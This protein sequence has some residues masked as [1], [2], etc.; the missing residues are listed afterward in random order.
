MPEASNE[1]K[2]INDK[3]EKPLTLR[4]RVPAQETEELNN[5]PT[6]KIDEGTFD[7]EQI[8]Q[9]AVNNAVDQARQPSAFKKKEEALELLE[10]EMQKAAEEGKSRIRVVTNKGASKPKKKAKVKA[11]KKEE[12]KK[13]ISGK[14]KQGRLFP[15]KITMDVGGK[16]VTFNT[17]YE[18]FN[19]LADNMR[20]KYIHLLEVRGKEIQS[21]TNKTSSELS[22]AKTIKGYE[23]EKGVIEIMQPLIDM[24]VIRIKWIGEGKRKYVS[25]DRTIIG[26][27]EIAEQA[28]KTIIEIVQEREGRA[29]KIQKALCDGK[30]LEDLKE[31][32]DEIMENAQNR[33]KSRRTIDQVLTP[34]IEEGIIRRKKQGKR[35]FYVSNDLKNEELTEITKEIN[36]K[37]D[38]IDAGIMANAKEYEEVLR[39][40]YE[41]TKI[42]GKDVK[43][44]YQLKIEK[45]PGTTQKAITVE[46]LAIKFGHG[47]IPSNFKEGA[48][49]ISTN[50]QTPQFLKNRLVKIEAAEKEVAEKETSEK[51]EKEK[52]DSVAA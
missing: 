52:S 26:T 34:F 51:V 39:G 46:K 10:A 3:P 38:E 6:I 36:R 49:F 31:V 43:F 12:T 32:R 37:C 17:P 25:V 47:V 4:Q 40:G 11:K 19:S 30:L 20:D 18:A 21:A 33:V 50:P 5:E 15:L 23:Q 2:N 45:I 16:I 29:D 13:K 1:A 22:N 42:N 9:E 44:A 7:I 28:N 48:T 24:Q 14:E 41:E 35:I 27:E 8:V